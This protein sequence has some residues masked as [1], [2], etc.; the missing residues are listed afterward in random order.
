M[1]MMTMTK[2]T[3]LSSFFP[4]PIGSEGSRS[5]TLVAF[6]RQSVHEGAKVLKPTHSPPLPPGNISG[7]NFCYRLDSIPGP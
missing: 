1:I 7:T 2:T 3:T 6:F 5:V 4:I